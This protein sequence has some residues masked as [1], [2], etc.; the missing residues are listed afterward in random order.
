V[1]FVFDGNLFTISFGG[2]LR[3]GLGFRYG[4]FPHLESRFPT[5][6]KGMPDRISARLLG[7]VPRQSSLPD[8]GVTASRSSSSVPGTSIP[9]SL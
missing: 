7:P 2:T 6:F 3:D 9:W 5:A 8:Y 1:S 4:V